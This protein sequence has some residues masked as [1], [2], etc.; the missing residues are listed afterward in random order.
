VNSDVVGWVAGAVLGT[1]FSILTTIFI[2]STRKPH[3]GIVLTKP[4]DI[5][6]RPEDEKPV[7][8]MRSV[9]LMVINE[10]LPV[11]LR[12]LSRETAVQCHAEIGFRRLDTGDDVFAGKMAGRW[13]NSPEIIRGYVATKKRLFPIIDFA[14]E[15]RK[16]ITAGR[17]ELLDIVTRYDDDES[18]YGWNNEIYFS[19]WRNPKWML[20]P[21]R[22]LV[23]VTIF[24]AGEKHTQTFRLL[25]D[26]PKSELCISLTHTSDLMPAD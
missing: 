23:D 25:N 15:T 9:R 22:Y 17:E 1:V 4:Y 19:G 14:L 24:S 26:V 3:L 5:E 21:G 20:P 16:D 8:N 12:W 13:T 6:Y 11:G 2:E 10:P 7:N 18:C